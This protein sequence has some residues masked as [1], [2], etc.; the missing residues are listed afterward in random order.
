MD[1]V[2]CDAGPAVGESDG[3]TRFEVPLGGIRWR[4]FSRRGR[5]FVLPDMDAPNIASQR[6][7][8]GGSHPGPVAPAGVHPGFRGP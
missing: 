7:L 1:A 5:L 8:T 3:A 6:Q 2:G 4:S